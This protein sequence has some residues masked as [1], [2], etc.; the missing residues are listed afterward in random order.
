MTDIILFRRNSNEAR[1][2]ASNSS[3][4]PGQSREHFALHGET[5]STGQCFLSSPRSPLPTR[6]FAANHQRLSIKSDDLIGRWVHTVRIFDSFKGD[7]LLKGRVIQR[8]ETSLVVL[9]GLGITVTDGRG[10]RRRDA[11]KRNWHR[12]GQIGSRRKKESEKREEEEIMI[13]E[14]IY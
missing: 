7:G 8:R 13:S 11:G 3:S 12:G 14:K 9:D 10:G 2:T 1:N 4:L 6:R 5:L